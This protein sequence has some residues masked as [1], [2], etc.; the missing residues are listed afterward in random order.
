[1]FLLYT[2]AAHNRPLRITDLRLL[3]LTLRANVSLI[4]KRSLSYKG[5]KRGELVAKVRRN[6]QE[7]CWR[8]N[9]VI[10][11]RN[12]NNN[13]THASSVRGSDGDV[14]DDVDEEM[15]GEVKEKTAH[16]QK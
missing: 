9:L 10:L 12:N 7:K 15:N 3:F 2:R 6:C 16:K 1:M 5:E 11:E 8:R 14:D 13:K 4:L